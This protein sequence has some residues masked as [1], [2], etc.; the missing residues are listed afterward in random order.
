MYAEPAARCKERLRLCCSMRAAEANS[1]PVTMQNRLRQTSEARMIDPGEINWPGTAWNQLFE[2][3]KAKMLNGR[4]RASRPLS[5][6]TGRRVLPPS[7]AMRLEK[8]LPAAVQRS[9]VASMIPR[10]ISLPLKTT[11]SSRRR[12]ICPTTALNP[13]RTSAAWAP[14][15][16]PGFKLCCSGFGQHLHKSGI[17]IQP[18]SQTQDR[19]CFR[20][21]PSAVS[22]SLWAMFPGGS[23]LRMYPRLLIDSVVVIHDDKSAFVRKPA[24]GSCL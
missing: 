2:A 11:I 16:R 6:A 3:R 17:R 24:A 12:R 13:V 21:A 19:P 10:D 1:A 23:S 4:L 22:G 14:R 8:P 20:F 5:A 7:S 18:G 15:Y 9:Q